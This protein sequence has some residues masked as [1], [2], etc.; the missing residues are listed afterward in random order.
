MNQQEIVHRVSTTLLCENVYVQLDGTVA[1]TPF[2]MP[3]KGL[4]YFEG[5]FF[6]QKQPNKDSK[7]IG[8]G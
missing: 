8:K 2:E 6:Y 7:L 3:R 4:W 1:P 5:Q